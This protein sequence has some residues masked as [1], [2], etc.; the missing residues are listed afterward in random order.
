MTGW[1]EAAA[2]ARRKSKGCVSDEIA[3]AAAEAV[4]CEGAMCS[5]HP[6]AVA[7]YNVRWSDISTWI[8]SV[9]DTNVEGI[10]SVRGVRTEWLW[11]QYGTFRC[12]GVRCLT[13]TPV[14]TLDICL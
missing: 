9:F 5:R 2:A 6:R 7:R 10:A 14:Q 13:A 1:D 11:S 4:R 3:N 12:V 8:C